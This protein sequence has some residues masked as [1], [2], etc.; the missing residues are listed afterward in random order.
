MGTDVAPEPAYALFSDNGAF[1][2]LHAANT[3]GTKTPLYCQ[4]C[5]LLMLVLIITWMF[6]HLCCQVDSPKIIWHFYLPNYRTIFFFTKKRRQHHALD[7]F[8]PDRA[9]TCICRCHS[10]LCSHTMVFENFWKCSWS[11]TVIYMTELCLVLMHCFP[12]VRRSQAS[13]AVLFFGLGLCTQKFL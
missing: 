9:L 5:R 3:I 13:S 7:Y 8:S 2:D 11:H 12:S 10:E 4:T 6:P 1:P